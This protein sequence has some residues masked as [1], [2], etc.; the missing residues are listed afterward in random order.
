[1]AKIARKIVKA[2]VTAAL[3]TCKSAAMTGSEGK[4]ML[5]ARI[6]VAARAQIT[7]LRAAAPA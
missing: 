2:D 3:D 6:P 4:K 5:V 1:M 7:I